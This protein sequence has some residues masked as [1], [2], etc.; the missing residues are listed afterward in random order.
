M[1]K[2][3]KHRYTEAVLFDGDAGMTDRAVQ[4]PMSS[5]RTARTFPVP[6]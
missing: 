1:S 2:Q 4:L 6:F 3:I 5:G